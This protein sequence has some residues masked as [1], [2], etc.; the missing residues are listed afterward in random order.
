MSKAVITGAS[1]GIGRIVALRLAELDFELVLVARSRSGLEETLQEIK[2]RKGAARVHLVDL[3]LTLQTSSQQL[4][5]KCGLTDVLILNAGTGTAGAFL[6]Q[7]LKNIH[8][9]QDLNMI[10][11]TDLCWLFGQKMRQQKQGHIVLISSM[12]AEVPAPYLSVYSATKA[13]VQTLGRCLFEEFKQDKIRVSVVCP[14]GIKTQFHKKI[15]LSDQIAKKFEWTML[16]PEVVADSVIS[17]LKR[18][19]PL[20]IPGIT[21]RIFCCVLPFF[22]KQF[23]IKKLGQLYKNFLP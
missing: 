6:N 10:S 9:M 15:G 19:R 1:E 12:V 3:D 4:V 7:P 14:G 17:A 20:I 23:L 8:Q 5:E 16:S 2:R 13:Y 18:P 22:S 11:L 21:N